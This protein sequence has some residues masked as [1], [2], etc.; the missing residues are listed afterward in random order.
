MYVL[1]PR[2]GVQPPR[3][4]GGDD[5]V[6][7][8]GEVPQERGLAARDAG[9]RGGGEGGGAQTPALEARAAL[10]AGYGGDVEVVG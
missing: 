2:R 5:V 7:R 4:P 10:V 6:G 1:V 8:V 3:E 9:L